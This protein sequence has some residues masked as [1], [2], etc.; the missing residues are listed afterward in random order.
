MLVCTLKLLVIESTFKQNYGHESI[1]NKRVIVH[2]P[3]AFSF[4]GNTKKSSFNSRPT[5][6]N[7][8]RNTFIIC[9]KANISVMGK[10]EKVLL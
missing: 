6:I 5:H 4:L 3:D 1:F 2:A 9:C 7:T 10:K 8:A